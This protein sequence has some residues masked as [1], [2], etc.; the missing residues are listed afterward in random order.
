MKRIVITG[1]RGQLG[2][3]LMHL[4]HTD[5]HVFAPSKQELDITQ[6]RQV[7]QYIEDVKPY[8]IIHAAA[9]T[10]V[11]EAEIDPSMPILVN[12]VGTRFLATAAEQV[13]ARMLYISTDYVFDG[14]QASPYAE[15][16]FPSPINVYGL[17]KLAGEKFVAGICSRYTIIRTSWLYGRSR[18][19]F[20][21]NV[22]EMAK[23]GRKIRMIED[24]IGSPT[25]TEDVAKCIKH[26][27]RIDSH[28]IYHASNE[29]SCSRYEFAS[30][31]V[32]FMGIKSTIIPCKS[33]DFPILARRPRNSVLISRR[34][35][36]AMRH[37]KS[38]LQDYMDEDNNGASHKDLDIDP[39]DQLF[40]ESI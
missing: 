13:G 36:P 24:Q 35:L 12:A 16:D 20:V 15:E 25:N 37:W 19:N 9:F 21:V 10:K 2:I 23:Q 26:L 18:N 33:E 28:G 29:G 32:K 11:D 8:A 14:A 34:G 7:E 6:K 27:L 4:L 38:A 31:I 17:S 30:A 22:V 3:E 40:Y 1:G 5:Y 39:N